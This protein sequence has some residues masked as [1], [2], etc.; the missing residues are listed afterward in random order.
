MNDKK[1]KQV[2]VVKNLKTFNKGGQN[3]EQQPVLLQRHK[4]LIYLN[5]TS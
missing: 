4:N 5:F 3:T 1:K 2:Y